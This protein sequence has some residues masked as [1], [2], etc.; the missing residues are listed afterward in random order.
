MYSFTDKRSISVV[1]SEY[2]SSR[3]SSRN[4]YAEDE[5]VI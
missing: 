2:K 4:K 5:D 1:P 3:I